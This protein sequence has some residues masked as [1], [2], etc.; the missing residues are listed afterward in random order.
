MIIIFLIISPIINCVSAADKYN[1]NFSKSEIIDDFSFNFV[2]LKAVWKNCD[3]YGFSTFGLHFSWFWWMSGY[4][5]QHIS[6]YLLKDAELRV[7]GKLID[8]E[9]AYPENVFFV[10]FKGIAPSLIWWANQ[11]PENGGDGN[12]SFTI[13]GVCNWILYAD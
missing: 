5:Q 9:D 11:D 6:V 2:V 3:L 4:L 7:N 10:G 12:A 1:K 13:I 8:L